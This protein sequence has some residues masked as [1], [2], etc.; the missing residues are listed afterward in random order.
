MVLQSLAGASREVK[1]HL[2]NS[3]LW[4]SLLPQARLDAVSAVAILRTLSALVTDD[5]D[6]KD[7][8]GKSLHLLDVIER[9][10]LDIKTSRPSEESQESAEILGFLCRLTARHVE[11]KRR[12]LNT[13]LPRCAVECCIESKASDEARLAA[14][15]FL[16]NLCGDEY[17]RQELIAAGA[18]R[19]TAILCIGSEDLARCGRLLET[20]LQ[21]PLEETA[22]VIVQQQGTAFDGLFAVRGGRGST[23]VSDTCASKVAEPSLNLVSKG[24]S[25]VEEKQRHVASSEDQQIRQPAYQ[26]R[27]PKSKWDHVDT[28]A[29]DDDD[30]ASDP[31]C[32]KFA[33]KSVLKGLNEAIQQYN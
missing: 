28:K 24:K 27:H 23:R 13:E 12:C 20:Y 11:N 25:N 16:V 8:V 2:A 10:L 29:E 7:A 1:L 30:C 14:C 5:I 31:G 33:K 17:A 32:V 26:R 18:S 9:R 19:A 22:D 6:A 3:E 15:G 21:A 4:A